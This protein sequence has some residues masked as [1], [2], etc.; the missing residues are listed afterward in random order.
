MSSKRESKDSASSSKK[1]PPWNSRVK[2][3]HQDKTRR[4][5]ACNVTTTTITQCKNTQKDFL[6]KTR[7]YS[8][9]KKHVSPILGVNQSV[10]MSSKNLMIHCIHRDSKC[11][12]REYSIFVSNRVSFK[13]LT[14]REKDKFTATKMLGREVRN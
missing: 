10:M 4:S 11:R 13:R 5:L 1:D 7:A 3:H 6:R 8:Q 12:R 9:D 14:K 2:G